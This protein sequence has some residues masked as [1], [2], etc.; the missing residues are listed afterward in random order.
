MS[1]IAWRNYVIIICVII[2]L[3][4]MQLLHERT[5]TANDIRFEMSNI[6]VW[7]QLKHENFI[8]QYF[9]HLTSIKDNFCIVEM[10]W[11]NSTIWCN[12]II[13]ICWNSWCAATA[14]AHIH[15]ERH[16]FRNVEHSNLKATE[17]WKFHFRISFA[18]D[19]DKT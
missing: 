2:A 19:I 5:Y 11:V 7:E 4:E 16:S 12:Y 14:R 8:S 10:R 18:F 15:C 3:H 1:F 9:L 17:A 6:Q 13:I